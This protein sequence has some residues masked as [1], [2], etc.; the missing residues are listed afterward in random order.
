MCTAAGHP[1]LPLSPVPQTALS[2][3]P[4]PR[5][6]KL[7]RILA[8]SLGGNSKTTLVCN[9]SPSHDNVEETH[10]TLRFATQAKKVINIAKVNEIISDAAVIKNQEK[11]IEDLKK[12]LGR[13]R[14]AKKMDAVVKKLQDLRSARQDAERAADESKR[15]LMNTMR[16]DGGGRCCL[17]V[18]AHAYLAACKY[19]SWL[20]CRI[21]AVS[22]HG[23]IACGFFCAGFVS[24]CLFGCLAVPLMC[25]PS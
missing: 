20:A 12:Q 25:L 4:S 23:C 7:T 10:N 13:F 3:S 6:S 9:V 1:T 24:G 11:E 19:S 15:R 21:C 17:S 2:S 8:S 14:N 16:S 5:D 22:P 18:C